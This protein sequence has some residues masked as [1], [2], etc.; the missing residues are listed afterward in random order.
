MKKC[1]QLIEKA[2]ISKNQINISHL[3]RID[4][5]RFLT[6]SNGIVSLMI[7]HIYCRAHQHL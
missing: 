1:R 7:Y 4:E 5:I 2:K 3:H 6:P